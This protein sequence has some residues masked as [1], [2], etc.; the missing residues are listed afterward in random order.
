MKILNPR[1]SDIQNSILE[2]L[3]VQAHVVAWPNKSVGIFD[4]KTKVFRKPKSRF[5]RNGV[6]DILGYFK[7]S[8]RILAIEVK[9]PNKS[10]TSKE[11]KEFIEEVNS[12]GGLA[13]IATSVEDVAKKLL[14]EI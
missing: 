11:Q 9:R 10:T 6:P 7:G 4:P 1:E 2:F 5:H 8:G 13:F 3:S 14:E 12:N